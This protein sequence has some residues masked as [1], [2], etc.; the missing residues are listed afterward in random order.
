[1]GA[2]AELLPPL[3]SRFYATRSTSGT[4][5]RLSASSTGRTSMRMILR[6]VDGS[7]GK[8]QRVT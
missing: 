5:V 6:P 2:F 4:D 3:N 1:M 7:E 8:F